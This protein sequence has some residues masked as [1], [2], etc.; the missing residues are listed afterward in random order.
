VNARTI[1][2]GHDRAADIAAIAQ[3]FQR[4]LAAAQ[5]SQPAAS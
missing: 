4:V 2:N 1:I 3:N 5:L